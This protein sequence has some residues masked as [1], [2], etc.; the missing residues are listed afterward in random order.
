MNLGHSAVDTPLTAQTAPAL[1]EFILRLIEFHKAKV[2]RVFELSKL[3]ESLFSF[4]KN[5]MCF[6]KNALNS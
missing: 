2:K 4:Q 5:Y 1:N 3:I 6:D